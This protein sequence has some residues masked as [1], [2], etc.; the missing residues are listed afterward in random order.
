MHCKSTGRQLSRCTWPAGASPC[1]SAPIVVGSCPSWSSFLLLAYTTHRCRPADSA[2]ILPEQPTQADVKLPCPNIC[3]K[4]AWRGNSLAFS[5]DWHRC[6]AVTLQTC[7]WHFMHGGCQ[8]EP[9]GAQQSMHRQQA[10]ARQQEQRKA[11]HSFLYYAHSTC[12]P[13]SQSQPIQHLGH[14]S[15]LSPCSRRAT[16]P[17]QSAGLAKRAVCNAIRQKPL[18]QCTCRLNAGPTRRRPVCSNR[19][20]LSK[21]SRK[22]AINR[23]PPASCLETLPDT[24]LAPCLLH[25]FDKSHCVWQ[26]WCHLHKGECSL[27]Q[28]PDVC[29]SALTAFNIQHP[30]LHRW[31]S[32]LANCTRSALKTRACSR[33]GSSRLLV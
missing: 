7:R 15:G 8:S 27:L 30:A 5:L 23:C 1:H 13:K 20:C 2:A 26:V 18:Q 11:H 16:A 14:G 6:A 28:H 10:M 31:G 29:Y 3:A 12:C 22:G 9:P 19:Q 33:S 21:G 25:E 24:L 17:E 4:A 32:F